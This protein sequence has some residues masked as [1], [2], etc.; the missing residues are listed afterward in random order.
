MFDKYLN[1]LEKEIMLHQEFMSIKN[2]NKRWIK[3][4]S[5]DINTQK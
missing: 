4:G 5:F 1:Y 2:F 3:D